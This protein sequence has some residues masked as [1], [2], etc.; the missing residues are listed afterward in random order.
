M[1]YLSRYAKAELSVSHS[2]AN[3]SRPA[4]QWVNGHSVNPKSK[5]TSVSTAMTDSA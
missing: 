2:V 1:Q 5:G 4:A 3:H